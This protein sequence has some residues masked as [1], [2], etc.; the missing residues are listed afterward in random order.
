M[1]SKREL[2]YI[3]TH[4]FKVL[5]YVSDENYVE[6][7]SKCS[8]DYWIIKK[9]SFLMSDYPIILY[10]KHPGQP[11]YHKHWQCYEVAQ[12]VKSIKSHDKYK[13]LRKWES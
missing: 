8:K 9:T 10:H 3:D 7:Q 13:R 12:S 2:S 6:I 5:R 4:Y 1:F 11:Y